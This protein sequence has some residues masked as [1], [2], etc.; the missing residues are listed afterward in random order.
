MCRQTDTH[1]EDYYN[2]PPTPGLIIDC[3]QF[4]E[5]KNTYRPFQLQVHQFLQ[6]VLVFP[7]YEHCHILNI[8]HEHLP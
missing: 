6:Q 3:I 2:P 8:P 5:L 7:H 4:I 1:T